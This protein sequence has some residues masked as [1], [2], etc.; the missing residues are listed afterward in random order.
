MSFTPRRVLVVDDDEQTA[1]L[2][3]RLL[4]RRGHEV[5]VAHDVDGALREA[6]A[7]EPQVALLD[8]MVRC[9]S[10]Y[11]LARELLALPRLEHCRLIALTGFAQ[12]QLRQRSEA[13][14]FYEHLTKPV[15]DAALF[16][17]VETTEASEP[18]EPAAPRAATG[19][20]A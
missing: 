10:G 15:D 5:R 14:G 2:L 16:R 19:T 18:T 17:A 11:Y 1:E 6:H 3:Q 7:F 20:G 8:L 12:E 4:S 9:E 13:A